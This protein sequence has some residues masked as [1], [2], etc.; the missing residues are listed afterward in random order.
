[1]VSCLYL[2]FN[3]WA[4]RGIVVANGTVGIN[5]LLV[6]VTIALKCLMARLMS[7]WSAI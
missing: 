7:W 6:L 1:M 2:E 4:E 3:V 5:C